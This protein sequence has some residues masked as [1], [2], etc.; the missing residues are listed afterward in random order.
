MAKVAGILKKLV[1]EECAAYV[2]GECLGVDPKN[3]VF[4][5]E[6]PCLVYQGENCDVFRRL[7]LPLA[8]EV[9]LF[10]DCGSRLQE[11]KRICIVCDRRR[12]AQRARDRKG[13]ETGV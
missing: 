2:G 5:E 1:R 11:G 7:I 13:R 3:R 12:R 9:V 8:G 10:C 6:G 4:R